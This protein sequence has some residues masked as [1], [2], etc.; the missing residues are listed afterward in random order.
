MEM[1]QL[2]SKLKHGAVHRAAGNR[3]GAFGL[4]LRG[5]HH[6]QQLPSLNLANYNAC[7][8]FQKIDLTTPGL[9]LVH[10]RPYMFVVPNFFS[11]DECA[12][13]RAKAEPALLPQGFDRAAGRSRTSQGCTM[14]NDEV[15]GLRDRL[16]RL[17]GV[18]TSQMQA[19]KVSRY[20]AGERFDI[21]TDAW[22]GALLRG[23]RPVRND[24]WADKARL[25]RGVP[26]ARVLGVNRTCTI[27][28]YLNTCA[29]GGRT[30]WRW[31]A[32]DAALGGTHHQSF[33]DTPGPGGGRTDVANGS[34]DD[35]SI[36][37]EEGLA[38]VHFPSVVPSAGGFTDYNA[39]HEAEPPHGG[40]VKWVA[41]QFCWSHR[42]L[43]LRRILDREN[44]E[45]H[46]ARSAVVL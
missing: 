33:Y 29:K 23:Q 11:A 12:A 5:Y 20:R 35:V 3:L 16:A 43:P 2:M 1:K 36:R 45:P 15:P 24:W 34:G 9:Q 10:E 17:A 28:V 7:N 37:P 18:H 31:T 40:E 4:A 42:D 44:W 46:E 30:R 38:V 8:L 6:Y 14:R 22:R 21:H 27:F 32:H 41:Q 39:Y 13:L 19:L 26:G 25:K